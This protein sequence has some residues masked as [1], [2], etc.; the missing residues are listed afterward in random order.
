MSIIDD[1][2]DVNMP[3]FQNHSYLEW[4]ESF[5]IDETIPEDRRPTYHMLMRKLWSIPYEQIDGG[6]GNDRDRLSEGL[7]LRIRYDYILSRNSGLESSKVVDTAAMFGPCRVLEVLVTLA[8]HMYDIMQDTDIY[9]SVSRWFWEI[10]SNVGFESLDDDVFESRDEALIEGVVDNILSGNGGKG[11]PG[12]WFFI[13]NWQEMEVWYQMH[14][15]ISKY[16]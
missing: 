11:R 10:M 1:S 3:Y 16:F 15:Y 4:L 14:E 8:M 5:T 6:V 9:N 7:E 13:E 2:Y 12:G